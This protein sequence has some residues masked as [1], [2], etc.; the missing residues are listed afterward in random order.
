MEPTATALVLELPEAFV[1]LLRDALLHLYDPVQLQSHPL[2]RLAPG[3]TGSGGVGKGRLLRQALLDAIEALQPERGVAATSRA[4]R[5]Y[6]ILDL[7]YLE[8]L[9]VAEVIGRVALSKSQ[10]HRE[11]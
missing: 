6:R 2:L 11:H 5:A 3:D 10:Y 9:D 1:D 7:R 8:A 4:W